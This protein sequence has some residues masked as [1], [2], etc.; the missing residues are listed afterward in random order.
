MSNGMLFFFLPSRAREGLFRPIRPEK[1]LSNYMQSAARSFFDNLLF[2]ECCMRGCLM[3]R[4]D[5]SIGDARQIKYEVQV[6]CPV[7]VWLSFSE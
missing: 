7:T 2:E 5:F 4:L 1:G 3:R 6:N